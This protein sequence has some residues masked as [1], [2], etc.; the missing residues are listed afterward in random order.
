MKDLV[1]V[2]PET[3]KKEI[4]ETFQARRKVL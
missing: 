1:S 4:E 2:E 3:R